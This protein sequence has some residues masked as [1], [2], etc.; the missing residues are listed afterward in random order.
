M[1]VINNLPGG[2]KN[3]KIVDR[4][5]SSSASGYYVMQ[6]EDGTNASFDNCAP[7]GVVCLSNT[8]STNYGAVFYTGTA[9]PYTIGV[10]ILKMNGTGNIEFVNITS[11][12][13]FIFSYIPK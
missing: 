10:R 12:L 8:A 9:A 2:G 7:L 4:T 13:R 5:L 1:S 11:P 6:L 3:A